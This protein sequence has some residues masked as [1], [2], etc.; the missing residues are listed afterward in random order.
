MRD[1]LTLPDSRLRSMI[2]GAFRYGAERERLGEIRNT[3]DAYAH[4]EHH[5]NRLVDEFIEGGHIVRSHRATE[6]REQGEAFDPLTNLPGEYEVGQAIRNAVEHDAETMRFYLTVSVGALAQHICRLLASP[7]PSGKGEH[8]ATEAIQMVRHRLD[9]SEP[10]DFAE[11]LGLRSLLEARPNLVRNSQRW[12][13]AL[14]LVTLAG[15]W[16]TEGP[17]QDAVIVSTHSSWW[18]SGTT[19]ELENRAR[20]ARLGVWGEP[21]DTIRVVPVTRH[22]MFGVRTYTWKPGVTP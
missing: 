10:I 4:S 1:P 6:A 18:S 11:L 21:G 2:A 12:F 3:E 15:C 13:L 8:P 16:S 22:D 7:A 20:I 17:P 5:A 14:L 19:V 9:D